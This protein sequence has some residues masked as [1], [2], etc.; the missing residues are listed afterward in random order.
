MKLAEAL[1]IRK[2]L[3]TKIAQLES[4]ICNNVRIQ[5]GDEPSE[6]PSELLKTLDSCLKQLEGLIAKINATNMHTMVDGRTLTAMMA[7]R[8][9]LAKRI[10]VLRAV[11]DKASSS[12][13]RYSRSEIKYVT[14]IDVKALSKQIDTLS[15]K[16]RKLDIEIQ[17]AN[18]NTEL[19]K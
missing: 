2:D 12:Q 1:S 17:T 11:F 9:V 15:Q 19:E 5:E 18:F 7:E 13:D 14:M 4:R 8:E 6:D 10:N 3:Q 16:L